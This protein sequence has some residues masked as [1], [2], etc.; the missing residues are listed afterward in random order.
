MDKFIIAWLVANLLVSALIL[1]NWL[2]AKR[3]QRKR[4]AACSHKW[5]YYLHRP[6]HMESIRRLCA[7]CYTDER[8]EPTAEH[9]RQAGCNV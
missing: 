4:E 7:H 8:A 6:N 5:F 1:A 2:H 9:L 3:R